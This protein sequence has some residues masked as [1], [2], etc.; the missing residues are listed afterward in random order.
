M[1]LLPAP[2]NPDMAA[3][4]AA[5]QDFLRDAS[6]LGDSRLQGYAIYRDYYEGKQRALL[7]DR[8]LVY[9]QRTHVLWS[10]NFCE[11]IVDVLVQGLHVLGFLCED[12]NDDDTPEDGAE[13][14][15]SADSKTDAEALADMLG[16]WWQQN[17]MDAKESTIYDHASVEGDAF[18]IVDYDQDQQ[19]PRF[20]IQNPYTMKVVYSD[21][22][23]DLMLY[24]VKVWNTRFLPSTDPEDIATTEAI[25]IR[26]MNLYWPD[27]V[28]KWFTTEADGTGG[29]AANWHPWM[30]AGET[31]WPIMMTGA[32]GKSLECVV[33]FRPKA[34]GRQYGRSDLHSVIPQQD[35]LNKAIL[36][37]N[38]IMDYEGVPSR[39][40][41][42]V[43]DVSA[44]KV[45]PGEVWSAP[46]A[47]ARFGQFDIPDITPL[48]DAI[49]A[50][51][52]RMATRSSTPMHL[53]NP[54]GALPS[55][56][57][58]KVADAPRVAKA[59][60]RQIDHGNSFE[61]M[62]RLAVRWHNTFAPQGA[63]RFDEG[64]KVLTQWDDPQSRNDE[65][66]ARTAGYWH[67]LG[68]SKATLMAKAGFNPEE[69]REKRAEED[70]EALD[71]GMLG[72][73]LPDVADA[74]PQ[75]AA[76]DALNPA[77][78]PTIPA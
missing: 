76:V 34:R 7:T 5:R 20:T 1:S 32:D 55:G 24:A 4:A 69:E 65:S 23:P 54:T 16:D 21:D 46:T 58:Q 72:G 22:D 48:L 66:E 61:R 27:R 50:A 52:S 63:P 37:L 38:G 56:E 77:G 15:A 19:R 14:G 41:T 78:G 57:S 43:Q 18:V 67:D 75:G 47:E 71:H 73:G 45:A 68:V 64:M 33:H 17:Q 28:E 49:R 59:V 39:W 10:E 42:G 70:A 35:G 2:L 51:L 30:D 53:L 29:A 26:R 40:A 3:Q 36:D 6:D 74:L 60:D 25:P 8:A 31:G 9:L 13:D 11:P 44:L 62:M 12:S